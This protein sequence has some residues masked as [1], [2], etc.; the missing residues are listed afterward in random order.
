M[1]LKDIID[2]DFA[3]YKLPSMFLSTSYC[4]WKCCIEANIPI[5]VCQNHLISQ[6]DNIKVSA[7]EIFRRYQ[8]NPITHALVIAGLEPI[9]QFDEVLDVIKCFRNNGCEDDIIL[10]TGYYKHE[11][12]VQI[13]T[14]KY[15]KNIVIKFGRYKE[16]DVHHFDNTLGVFLTNKEQY[17]ERIS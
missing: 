2:E 13:E 9:L 12:P 11:L 5:S 14:L 8:S 3:N 4:T 7:D 17:A 10:Y 6:Q 16:G 1:I 15:Y